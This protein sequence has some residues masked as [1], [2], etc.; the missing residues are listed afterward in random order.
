[1]ENHY[2]GFWIRV[3]ATMIDSLL[4]IIIIFPLLTFIYGVGYWS[5]NIIV[6]GVWDVLLNYVLPA[7]VVIVFWLYRSATPGKMAL[8]MVIIDAKTGER[9]STGQLIGRYFAYYLSIIPFMLGF[10]WVGWDKRKQGWHDKLAGTLVVRVS[11][12]VSLDE[13]VRPEIES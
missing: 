2:A 7:I 8:G 1:V 13:D 10:F 12:E 5:E 3:G 6:S 11:K 9:P 4:M